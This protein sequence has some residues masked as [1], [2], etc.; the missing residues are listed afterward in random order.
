[1]F[2]ITTEMNASKSYAIAKNLKGFGP[3]G[4]ELR[5]RVLEVRDGTAFVIT[6]DLQD[7]GTRLAL[8]PEQLTPAE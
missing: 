3:M 8:K 4:T 1:M 2:Q 5:V 7:S 6:A